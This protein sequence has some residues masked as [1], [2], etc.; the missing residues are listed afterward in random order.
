[1]PDEPLPPQLVALGQLLAEVDARLAKAPVAPAGLEHLQQSVDNLRTSMWAILSV[2]QGQVA[3]SRIERLKLRR[4]IEG[5]R[6]IQ[7]DLAR[8]PNGDLQP[9]HREL[10]AVAREL[11]SRLDDS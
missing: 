8:R 7:E 1:M 6:A 3:P 4:A 10:A 2:G 11:A 5:L 9:E